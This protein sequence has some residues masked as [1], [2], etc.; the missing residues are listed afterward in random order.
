M[1]N[2]DDQ[3]MLSVKSSKKLQLSQKPDS[4]QK[5]FDLISSHALS[6]VSEKKNENEYDFSVYSH[7]QKF[8]W[9]N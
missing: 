4:P 9:R 5:L 8:E 2:Y 7:D 6:K 1:T 3:S